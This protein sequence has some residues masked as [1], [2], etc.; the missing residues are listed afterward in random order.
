ML[1]T[2]RTWLAA[3]GGAVVSSQLHPLLSFAG[4]QIHTLRAPPPVVALAESL[5]G[6]RF[7]DA[8]AELY[9]AMR[10]GGKFGIRYSLRKGEKPLT[11]EEVFKAK[12][13]DCSDLG[14][15]MVSGLMAL[16]VHERGD[17]KLGALLLHL[18]S[19]PPEIWHFVPFILKKDTMGDPFHYYAAFERDPAFKAQALSVL[20]VKNPW[21]HMLVVDPQAEVLGNFSI[22]KE[23]DEKYVVPLAGIEAAYYRE[24][25]MYALLRKDDALAQRM[26]EE[27]VRRCD[28]AL[29]HTN[30]S[31]LY[32]KLLRGS[33]DLVLIERALHHA[34]KAYGLHPRELER[35][36]YLVS[37]FN[38]A[39]SYGRVRQYEKALG[40]LQEAKKVA[41]ND[42]RTK[43]ELARL[44]Y[45]WG[46][47]LYNQGNHVEALVKLRQAAELGSAEAKNALS[48]IH[49]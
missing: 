15:W 29:A 46:A 47:Y 14:Y 30:L 34:Q 44:Y 3:V 35:D 27:S 41:S 42:P 48:T 39:N 20:G 13:G 24:Y 4:E 9:N 36:N 31:H 33:G 23:L 11:A 16:G 25:G 2:R 6:Q 21:W 43:E 32:D 18:K 17:A 1:L 22:E 26:F 49:E 12:K 10:V 37:L 38:A 7:S 19:S 28:D 45:N 40:Y 5:K 8:V